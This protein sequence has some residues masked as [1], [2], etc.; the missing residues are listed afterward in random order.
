VRLNSHGLATGV[1]RADVVV[2]TNDPDVSVVSVPVTLVVPAYQLGV[3]AGGAGYL[4]ARGDRFR[5]DSAYTAGSYGYVGTSSSQ[6]T[7][8]DIRNTR[9]DPLYQA[10]R[11]GMRQYRFD[12]PVDGTYT[13]QL[14][15]A[16]LEYNRNRQRV[17][18]VL[19]EGKPVLVNL[20][21]HRR[22][23]LRRALNFTFQAAV[24]DGTLNVRFSGQQGDAPMISAIFVTH[25]PDLGAGFE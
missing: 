23:G 2:L 18:T 19:V 3:N 8:R 9:D 21:V 20:D 7:S 17:F 24:S 11:V 12:V 16:E 5:P 10:A 4:T 6:R 1:Y 13:V 25:R 22:A 14:R 15:F